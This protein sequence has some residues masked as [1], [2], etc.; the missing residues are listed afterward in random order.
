MDEWTKNEWMNDVCMYEWIKN[1]QM[2]KWTN[3]RINEWINEW[4]NKVD[5]YFYTPFNL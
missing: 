3:E 1:E 2:Y 5:G 4:M